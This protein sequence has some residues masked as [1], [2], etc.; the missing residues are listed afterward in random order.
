MKV[1]GKAKLVGLV[2][3]AESGRLLGIDMLVERDSEGF[4][5]WQEWKSRLQNLLGDLLDDEGKRLMD[6]ERYVKEEPS[7]RRLAVDLCAKWRSLLYHKRMRW[8]CDTNNVTK[9][10]IAIR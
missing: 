1:R 7:L 10:V 4:A 3:D 8:V 9:R 5:D 2:A 6:M